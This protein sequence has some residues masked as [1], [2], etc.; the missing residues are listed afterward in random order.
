MG[1]VMAGRMGVQL[2]FAV[3]VATTGCG[4]KVRA[5][6]AGRSTHFRLFVGDDYNLGTLSSQEVLAGLETN[7][8]DTQTLLGMPEGKHPID[9]Y[10]LPDDEIGDACDSSEA[11]GCASD[12]TLYSSRSVD[13]HEL[14]HALC[15]VRRRLWAGASVPPVFDTDVRW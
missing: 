4:N 14:N 11:V 1:C 3:L 6:E 10:L 2:G 13:Q 12:G 5:H 7:W 9:Y 8:A 15:D